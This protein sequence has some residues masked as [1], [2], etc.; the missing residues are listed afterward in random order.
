MCED[1]DKNINQE[2][3]PQNSEAKRAI[4]G[5]VVVIIIAGVVVAV[6][7]VAAIVTVVVVVGVMRGLQQQIDDMPNGAVIICFVLLRQLD[8]FLHFFCLV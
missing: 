2:L 7:V 3:Q 4:S 1:A 6:V 5:I 8:F